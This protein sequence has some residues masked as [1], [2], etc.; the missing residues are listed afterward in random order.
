MLASPRRYDSSG[1][2]PPTV[3][4]SSASRTCCAS[5]S[6]SANTATV[7]TPTRRA[8]R[9]TRHAISPRLAISTFSN[10]LFLATDEHGWTR[11]KQENNGL[12]HAPTELWP[13]PE[14][15]Q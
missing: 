12:E 3:Y 6:A 7:R 11:I 15:D 1:R 10:I 9:I 4:A 2:G 5:R 13:G 8:V 14:V